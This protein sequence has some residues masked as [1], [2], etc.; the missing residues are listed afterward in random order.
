MLLN[1]RYDYRN[2][3][4]LQ[5]I[6][7]QQYIVDK[8]G[9]NADS[10]RHYEDSRGY[11]VDSDFPGAVSVTNRQYEETLNESKRRIKLISPQLINTILKNFK[12]QL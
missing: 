6:D 4:P 10:I 7:L 12:D 1:E 5:Y 9:S 8:Y 3:F 11:V 2:D